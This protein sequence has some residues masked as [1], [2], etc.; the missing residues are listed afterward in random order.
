MI[1]A[2]VVSIVLGYRLFLKGADGIGSGDGGG[3]S[4][5]ARSGNFSLSIKNAAPGT[6]F[7]LFGAALIVAMVVQA[8]PSLSVQPGSDGTRAV[9]M[10]GDGAAAAWN[11]AKSLARTGDV[12]AAMTAYGALAARPDARAHDIARVAAGMAEIYL[13][14]DR[15]LEALAM[16]RLSVQ[17]DGGEPQ[18]LLILAKAA[19]ANGLAAESRAAADRAKR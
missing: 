6:C 9:Q 7:A 19:E 3:T 13:T 10:K 18:F 2:G 17:I 14:Q 16:A 15:K 4:A 12:G 11:R 1:G 8:A 5:A